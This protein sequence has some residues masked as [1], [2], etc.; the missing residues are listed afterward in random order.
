MAWLFPL[1]PKTFIVLTFSEL[2]NNKRKKYARHQENLRW[3]FFKLR[4]IVASK[5]GVTTNTV[6]LPVW[7]VSYE[8]I[9]FREFFWWV[10]DK[11]TSR[12]S[13][14]L[15]CYTAWSRVLFQK[16]RIQRR[17]KPLSVHCICDFRPQCRKHLERRPAYV[18]NTRRLIIDSKQVLM[19]NG[20]ISS[21][22][23][24]RNVVVYICLP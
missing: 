7:H 11:N 22:I 24:S 4:G 23:D 15:R 14:A 13:L 3:V 9:E 21:D 18:H 12:T 1:T 6:Q 5:E 17:T 20:S 19:V 10:Q 2:R 8:S 16:K